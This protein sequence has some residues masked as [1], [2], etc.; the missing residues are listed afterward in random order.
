MGTLTKNSDRTAK[1][2][3]TP[4]TLEAWLVMTGVL[5]TI[6]GALCLLA[7]TIAPRLPWCAWVGPSSLGGAS[8]GFVVRRLVLLRLGRAAEWN[9]VDRALLVAHQLGALATL[10][11]IFLA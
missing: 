2:L 8:I 4:A 10:A 6:A 3:L 11:P 1:T 7:L 5:L 9:H